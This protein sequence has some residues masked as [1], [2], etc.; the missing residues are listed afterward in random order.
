MLILIGLYILNILKRFVTIINYMISDNL[1]S[2][3]ILIVYISK[4]ASSQ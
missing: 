3:I 4:L 2:Q 1:V